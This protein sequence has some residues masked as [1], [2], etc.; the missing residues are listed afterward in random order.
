MRL[1]PK[2]AH[3]HKNLYKPKKPKKGVNF[4]KKH[5]QIFFIWKKNL[6][7][8]PVIKR[9]ERINHIWSSSERN[10]PVIQGMSPLRIIFLHSLFPVSTFQLYKTG[11]TPCG[12]N[13]GLDFDCTAWT[14]MRTVIKSAIGDARR[15]ATLSSL[16][17][18]KNKGDWI[19]CD[20]PRTI[21]KWIL[22]SVFG[23]A[24]L[25]ADRRGAFF[26]LA[27]M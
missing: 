7:L 14:L 19:V 12:F 13:P 6:Y 21:F 25:R 2:R 9:A 3:K 5:P 23:M 4:V 1:I 16:S 24:S 27:P 18:V 17:E 20:S 11:F 10:F 8:S 22:K 26:I 15:L